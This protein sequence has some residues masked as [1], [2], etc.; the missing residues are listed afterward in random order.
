MYEPG[1]NQTNSDLSNPNNSNLL[2]SMAASPNLMNAI[3][4]QNS[5]DNSFEAVM[6]GT[7]RRY[8]MPM[9]AA[10]AARS[11]AFTASIPVDIPNLDS[12]PN[13][14]VSKKVRRLH[15]EQVNHPL[16][17]PP[18]MPQQEGIVQ[19][20]DAA[21]RKFSAS[22]TPNIDAL[23]QLHR[24]YQQCLLSNLMNPNSQDILLRLQQLN[25]LQAMQ[26]HPP[27]SLQPNFFSGGVNLQEAAS[28]PAVNLLNTPSV[29]AA[30]Q[31]QQQQNLSALNPLVAAQQSPLLTPVLINALLQNMHLSAQQQTPTT[32]LNGITNSAPIVTTSANIN[33]APTVP[34]S[35]TVLDLCNALLQQ[36]Q[37]SLVTVTSNN[38]PQQLQQIAAGPAPVVVNGQDTDVGRTNL[39]LNSKSSEPPSAK[40]SSVT[41]PS[42]R[43]HQ[44]PV[45]RRKL[46]ARIANIIAQEL[47]SDDEHR[48][49][50]ANHKS[51]RTEGDRK[52][53]SQSTSRTAMNQ[54]NLKR[55]LMETDANERKYSTNSSSSS[56][57][58]AID[59]DSSSSSKHNVELVH[60]INTPAPIMISPS[61]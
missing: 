3:L 38:Q 53:S 47:E 30:A 42:K 33:I 49:D 4:A 31:Q 10:N 50:G 6:P 61:S 1:K 19:Q 28:Q 48:D 45:C 18:S 14:P 5:S 29:A 15:S 12:D 40:T 37:P 2:A 36:Q 43:V 23:L 7:Q 44:V 21:N 51:D 20:M 22:A 58:M 27:V 54:V 17:P 41:P 55:E 46:E 56:E 11:S 25:S 8:T 9:D 52:A 35:T 59:T 60:K 39:K 24:L 13:A 57:D 32:V 26:T 16:F 34:A